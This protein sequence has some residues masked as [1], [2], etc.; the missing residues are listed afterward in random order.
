[1]PGK[2]ETPRRRRRRRPRRSSRLPIILLAL[3]LVAA[4]VFGVYHLVSRFFTPSNPNPGSSTTENSG[5]ASGSDPATQPPTEEPTEPKITKVSTATITATGDILMHKPVINTGYTS[6]GYNFDSIF[7]YID[8]YVTTADYA[9]AN[10]ETT[11]AGTKDGYN[12]SGYPTFNCPDEIVDS[13]KTAGFDMLL[14]ANN[15]C[16]D[17][18]TVG[19][20]RTLK[21]IGS[22]GIASLGTTSSSEDADYQVIDINGI[23]VGMV[24]YSYATGGTAAL[25]SLNGIPVRPGDENKVNTFHYNN[26][27]RF[28]N[29]MTTHIADMKAAGAEAIVLYT[30]WGEEYQLKPNNYQTTIAQKMCDLGVDVIVGGHPHVIQ[31]V[32]LLTSTTDEN[33]KTLCLYSMGNA[34]SNQRRANMNLKTGHTEDGVLF[35]FTFAKYSDGSVILESADILPTWVYLRT[36][37]Q[38]QYNILPLDKEIADWKTTFSFGDEANKAALASYDRTMAL[39]GEGLNKANTYFSGAQQAKEA[40][41]QQA[42]SVTAPSTEKNG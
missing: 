18:S 25:P 30:H 7:S 17:T 2:Y 35:S 13:V 32:D 27:D 23:K 14:T 28:Y 24:C 5:P 29:E 3:I 20:N 31:P 11:L 19:I 8:D 16:N 12:Y 4:L 42:G 10:L 6:N 21:V 36:G 22:K 33:H 26:L 9:V 38:T 34:V 37:G 41:Y 1:M 39:V 40:A 15:H